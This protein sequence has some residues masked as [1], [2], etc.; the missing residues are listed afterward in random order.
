LGYNISNNQ[1]EYQG[2]IDGLDYMYDNGISCCDLFIRGDS[3]I[4]INQMIGR[5]NVNSP[6]IIPYYN[7]ARNSLE[8][9]NCNSYNFRHIRRNENWEADSLANDA[10]DD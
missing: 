3:E 9:I 10:I 8:S 2:L 7:E 4:I 1:A 6:N 5:Y